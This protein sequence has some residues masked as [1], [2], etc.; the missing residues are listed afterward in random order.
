MTFQAFWNEK[1]VYSL[2]EQSK[3]II[4]YSSDGIKPKKATARTNM[5]QP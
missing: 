2:S 4:I 1:D 5:S 3:N